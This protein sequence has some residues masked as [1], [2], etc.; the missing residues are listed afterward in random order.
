ML[1]SAAEFAPI[2]Y[3][4]P[5]GESLI[6]E[7]PPYNGWGSMEDSLGNCKGL[8]PRPP[9]RDFIKFMEKDRKGLESHTL[10]FLARLVT[11]KPVDKERKFII[12]YFLSDDT[13]LVYEP[14]VRN[15]GVLGGKF[16]ERQRIKCPG[17]ERYSTEMPRYYQA[18]DLY[19]GAN[20]EINKF[21]FHL[22]SADEYAFCYMERHPEEAS[23][24]IVLLLIFVQ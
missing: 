21:V 17:Q 15:S 12:S 23:S 3:K 9:Q 18:R 1:F 6:R 2:A 14:P 13:I 24:A 19:V 20:L 8:L 7:D 4:K 11:D 5:S 10:R 16:L 22:E